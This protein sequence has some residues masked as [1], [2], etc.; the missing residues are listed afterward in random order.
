MEYLVRADELAIGDYLADNNLM[1]LKIRYINGYLM[2]EGYSR[3]N[4]VCSVV[5][6]DNELVRVTIKEN[7]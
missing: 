2:V 6:C 3:N 7:V 4:S 5:M 1:I